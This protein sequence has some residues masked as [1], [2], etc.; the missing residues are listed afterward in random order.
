MRQRAS[1]ATVAAGSCGA[2]PSPR[3]PRRRPLLAAPSQPIARAQQPGWARS[4]TPSRSPTHMT[5]RH[6]ARHACTR[7][8]ISTTRTRPPT[9]AQR[10]CGGSRRAAA[11]TASATNASRG[12]ETKGS[13]LPLRGTGGAQHQTS[14]R[15]CPAPPPGRTGSGLP[16]ST[17]GHGLPTPPHR[18]SDLA[19]LGLP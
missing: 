1:G 9:A 2:L 16:E 12:R 14:S 15:P 5:M 17:D 6:R 4:P 13:A 10:R 7:A 19:V 3:R 8:S 18:Q 11:I